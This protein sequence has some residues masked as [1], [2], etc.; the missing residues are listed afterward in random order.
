MDQGNIKS[1]RILVVEDNHINQKVIKGLLVIFGYEPDVVENG[2][3]AVEKVAEGAYDIVF[4]DCQMPE[5]DG[6]EATML[7]RESETDNHT[8]II[9]MTGNSMA[10]DREKC[11]A[12]GMDDYVSKPLRIE[13]LKSTLEK[14]IPTQ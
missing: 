3:Q 6:Y 13:E 12:C 10:G 7:I 2:K 14:W 11:L 5:M 1:C 9:A 8:V 4:M